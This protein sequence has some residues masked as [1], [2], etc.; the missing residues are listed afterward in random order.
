MKN[1][2]VGR[3]GNT[4]KSKSVQIPEPIIGKVYA[5]I[6]EFKAEQMKEGK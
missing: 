2:I 5:L 4:W 1:K 3:P 6:A